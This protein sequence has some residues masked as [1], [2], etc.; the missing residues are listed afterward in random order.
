MGIEI[1]TTFA[2]IKPLIISPQFLD[3]S[4]VV[5]A[6]LCNVVL[7]FVV[8][9]FKTFFLRGSNLISPLVS[10]IFLAQTTGKQFQ[11]V[12]E[13]CSILV[14]IFLFLKK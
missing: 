11:H 14:S 3:F 10:L 1:I 7:T 12:G 13:R 4:A 5:E 8:S 6:L 9:R 2:C